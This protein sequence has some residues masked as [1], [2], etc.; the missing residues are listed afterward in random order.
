VQTI[1]TRQIITHGDAGHLHHAA[2]YP[3][4][5]QKSLTPAFIPPPVGGE[6]AP[7]EE[8]PRHM[9]IST[10]A[11]SATGRA[12][13]QQRSALEFAPSTD[14]TNVV[15]RASCPRPRGHGEEGA[16]RDQ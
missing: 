10:F 7:Y 13:P 8:Y 3:H 2:Q 16:A 12:S 5:A 15:R 9:A 6:R 1:A 14:R 4:P 11:Y